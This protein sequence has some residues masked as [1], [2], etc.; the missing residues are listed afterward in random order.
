MPPQF[1]LY[2]N[3]EAKYQNA[4]YYWQHKIKSSQMIEQPSG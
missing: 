1:P 4:I 2:T 3:G